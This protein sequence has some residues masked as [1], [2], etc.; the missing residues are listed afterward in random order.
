MDNVLETKLET[1]NKDITSATETLTKVTQNAEEEKL[2]ESKTCTLI[3]HN[4]PEP[5]NPNKEDRVKH[6]ED[7]CLLS[8][9]IQQNL[10][11]G[12]W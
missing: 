3:I 1:V 9:N 4:V 12:G 5:D 6:D 2:R 8:K 11:G 7:F 10:T